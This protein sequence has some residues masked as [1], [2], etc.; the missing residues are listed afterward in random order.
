[1]QSSSAL[2]QKHEQL[3]FKYDY[4]SIPMVM[5]MTTCYD[6]NKDFILMIFCPQRTYHVHAFI[7]VQNSNDVWFRPMISDSYR[8]NEPHWLSPGLTFN[9]CGH[10]FRRV[11]RGQFNL[12]VYID[13]RPSLHDTHQFYYPHV[14]KWPSFCLNEII[15][16]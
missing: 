2:L 3:Y 16:F 13:L 7:A 12:V 8:T 1:M 4:A 11:L 14:S 6:E 15:Y 5:V 10:T 9:T